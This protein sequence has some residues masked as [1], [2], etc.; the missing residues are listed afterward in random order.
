MNHINNIIKDFRLFLRERLDITHERSNELDTIESIKKGVEFKGVNLWILIFAI[1]IASLGL[2]TNSTAV[3]I[4]AMLI[5]PLMGPIMGVGLGL[6]INDLELVNKSLK[7]LG[8]ATVFSILTAAIYFFITPLNEARSELLARTQPTIYDVM[9]A[10]FGG[11]AGIVAGSAKEKGN[12]IPGVAIATALMPPLCT[13][14]YGLGTGQWTFFLGA[15][16]LYFINSV[17]IS[18]ATYLGVQIMHFPKK[19]FMNPDRAKRVSR[20]VTT[21]VI[22]TIIPSIWI[23]YNMIG[24]S[25]FERNAEN[26]IRQELSFE[27]T[28]IVNKSVVTSGK[29]SIQVAIIG[30]KI[31]DQE[32]ENIRSKMGRYKLNDTELIISQGGTDNADITTLKTMVLE[33][34]YHNSERSIKKKELQIDLL[35]KDLE[36]Y[37]LLM[38]KSYEIAPEMKALFP[39]VKSLSFSKGIDYNIK[40]QSKDTVTIAVVEFEKAPDENGK[41]RLEEWLKA[42]TKSE[43]FKLLVE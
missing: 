30:K 35:S 24:Q 25:I 10:F 19:E 1:F 4:G 27:G 43:K 15:F 11:M 32:L 36:S 41:K 8:I 42:R 20:V 21:T 13:A 34:F 29:K 7:N 40:E 39:M 9:I 23:S 17:F 14:G 37:E 33:D 16:Y 18:L 22:L 3:I 2:N 12:V 38:R 28:Q 26:F 6:G 31:T 5:S